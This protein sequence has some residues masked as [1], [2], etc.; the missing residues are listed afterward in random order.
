MNTSE[1][2]ESAVGK[3]TKQVAH[4]SGIQPGTLYKWISGENKNCLDD[5]EALINNSPNGEE[6]IKHLCNKS[7][8]YFVKELQVEGHK[9][10]QI[11]P[12]TLREFSELM[13]AIADGLIDGKITR[14]EHDRIKNEL[15][16]VNSL[17][18]G[19]LNSCEKEIER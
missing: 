3:A 5:T 18:M 15:H 7:G 17:L 19:W 1:V 12:D 13:Q 2:L 4:D 14:Y 16:D 9:D 10:F 8:G 11:I 6:I